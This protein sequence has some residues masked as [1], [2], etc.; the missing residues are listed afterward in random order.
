M[1]RENGEKKGK[2]IKKGAKKKGKG[3]GRWEVWGIGTRVFQRLI[4][5]GRQREQECGCCPSLK[6]EGF[7]AT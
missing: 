5:P 2:V 1:K 3:G 7:R 6:E 4:L